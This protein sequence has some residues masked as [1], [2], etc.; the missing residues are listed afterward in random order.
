L[1]LASIGIHST[2]GGMAG[3]GALAQPPAAIAHNGGAGFDV[4]AQPFCFPSLK[5]A[6]DLGA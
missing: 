5:A 2:E 1:I 4:G 3:C 6:H